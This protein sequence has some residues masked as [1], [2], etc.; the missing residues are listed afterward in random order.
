MAS[1]YHGIQRRQLGNLP[2]TNF[3]RQLHRTVYTRLSLP[4]RMEDPVLHVKTSLNFNMSGNLL[5]ASGDHPD[6]SIWDWANGEKKAVYGSGHI[7]GVGQVKQKLMCC[8]I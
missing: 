7:G 5:T 1:I 6:I 3:S 8:D 4:I 2:P